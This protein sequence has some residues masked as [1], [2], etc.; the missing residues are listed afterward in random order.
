MNYGWWGSNIVFN[1][2]LS[3]RRGMNFYRNFVRMPN[4]VSAEKKNEN[5]KSGRANDGNGTK[6]FAAANWNI[7]L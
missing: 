5:E 4:C 7:I 2:L 6:E 1:T 3:L